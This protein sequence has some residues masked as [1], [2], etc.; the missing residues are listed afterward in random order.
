MESEQYTLYQKLLEDPSFLTWVKSDFVENDSKWSQ[1]ID[2]HDDQMDEINA[3]IRLVQSFQADGSSFIDSRLLWNRIRESAG[4]N[5]QSGSSGVKMVLMSRLT[6]LAAASVVL[7]LMVMLAVPGKT[8]VETEPGEDLT[9]E[10]PDG[11]TVRLGA[12]SKIEYHK[13]D[14]AADR[15]IY[16]EGFAFFEVKKGSK[17]QVQTKSGVVTV[18]GT[19]FSVQDRSGEFEVICRTGK[20]RVDI[21]K[22][23][24]MNLLPGQKASIEGFT[25]NLD[26]ETTEEGLTDVPWLQG[27]FTFENAEIRKVAEEIQY[28]FNVEIEM[29]ASIGTRK[30]TGFFKNSDL[31]MALQ[32]V[33]WPLNMQYTIK[34]HKVTVSPK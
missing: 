20:V 27:I 28:Q 17:F 16:L 24:S 9:T 34:G 10:L 4:L 26:L 11:S 1:F 32:S 6:W 15:N 30:Y 2:E 21:A 31:E 3:A 8:I 5:M 14:W 7:L 12:G 22:G 33:F 23:D 19:S 18:L 13:S 29:E 25:G